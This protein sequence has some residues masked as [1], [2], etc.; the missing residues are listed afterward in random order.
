MNPFDDPDGEF[1][2]LVNEE[3]QHSIWPSFA[4]VPDG[5]T[6]RF[7]PDARAACLAYVS[8]HWTD[9]RPRSLSR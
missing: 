6:A 3:G 7:G 1:L 4:E 9:L 8:A 2:V 5:W